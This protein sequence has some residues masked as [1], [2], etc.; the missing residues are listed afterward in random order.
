MSIAFQNH[1]AP[2]TSVIGDTLVDVVYWTLQADHEGFQ[3]DQPSAT[4]LAAIRL[5]FGSGGLEITWGWENSLLPNGAAY[6]IN[7][8][9]AQR[10]ELAGLWNTDTLSRVS[11]TNAVP[12]HGVIGETLSSVAILGPGESPQAI[13]FA[14]ASSAIV[15]AIGYSGDVL[16]LGDG[17]EL[18][19]FTEEEWAAL[20]AE[21]PQPWHRLW[22][23]AAPMRP[24]FAVK[25]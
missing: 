4:G 17:D 22:S 20:T 14:F 25:G 12:W 2:I 5:R 7:V 3:V 21:G 9:Q 15:V 10:P 23:A 8:T 18:L 19:V 24:A 13:R 16:C 11:A 6:H 1:T